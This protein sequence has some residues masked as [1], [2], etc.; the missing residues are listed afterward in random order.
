MLVWIAPP[1]VPR[2]ETSSPIL[3]TRIHSEPEVRTMEP[4]V[5]RTQSENLGLMETVR[6]RVRRS[7]RNSLHNLDPNIEW[8]SSDL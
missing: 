7:L 6:Q 3:G 2:V 1:R 8:I 5:A 4:P